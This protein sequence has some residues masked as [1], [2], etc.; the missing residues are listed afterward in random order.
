VGHF[1]P[2]NWPIP[3]GYFMGIFKPR[4]IQNPAIIA[5]RPWFQ[6]GARALLGGIFLSSGIAKVQ[7]LPL[8]ESAV[9]AYG[10]LPDVAATMVAK[11]LP[12]LEI[13][14]GSY[15]LLGLFTSYTSLMAAGMLIVF[16]G[17]IGWALLHNQEIDCGCY[18]GGQSDPISWQKWLEDL[19]LL[20]LAVYLYVEKL[21]R[22]SIDHYLSAVP[23]QTNDSDHSTD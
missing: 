7:N 9:K 19:G 5:L 21:G 13:V 1:E 10:I 11:A 23:R 20:L 15:L 2:Q 18:I 22:W 12:W 4:W 8:F 14:T 17:A 6:I 16:L 3:I